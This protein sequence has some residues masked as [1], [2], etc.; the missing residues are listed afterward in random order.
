MSR[1]GQWWHRT[2]NRRGEPMPARFEE[3]ARY[4]AARGV[5]YTDE[6]RAEMARLQADFDQWNRAS[7][8][9][10]ADRRGLTVTTL[11]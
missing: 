5:V 1:I 6:Y 11:P 3:L 8:R 2:V 7:Q 10:D 9:R 4:N